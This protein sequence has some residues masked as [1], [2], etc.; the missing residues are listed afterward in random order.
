MASIFV[1]PV[2]VMTP[3]DN[4]S[5]EGIEVWLANLDIWLKEALSAH[6]A[7]LHS[8]Q[9]T[10][11]LQDS[12]RFP[13]FELLRNWQRKYRLD[14]NPSQLVRGV[15]EFF[16][17]EEFDLGSILEK[18]GYLIEPEADSIIIRPDQFTAR[19]PDFIQDDMHLLLATSCACKYTEHPFTRELH[20]AT[21]VLPDVAKEIEVSAVILDS[22][23]DFVRN[24]DNKIHQTFPLL[25]TPDDLLPLI[26]VIKLW[27]QGETGIIYA[28]EQ[29]YKKDW[30]NSVSK[31]LEFRIGL[32]FIESANNFGLNTN[33]NVLRK[34]VR[35]AGAIIADQ[36]K[37]IQAYQLHELRESKAAESR[38]RVRS[39]DNAKAW[40]L[41]IEKHG[42]GWRLH[43]WQIPGPGESIIEFSNVEKESGDKIYE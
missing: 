22:I 8:V 14:F 33:D 30:R 3:P 15:N 11:L 1:D 41:M 17:N 25:F 18:L 31:P 23:P 9:A 12:G 39:S 13:S 37:H 16:R 38:Q 28:I 24:A 7:W 34:I 20:I 2:I 32:H 29:Q 19:W 26:D 27:S 40:R 5:R 21:L 4:E 10:N 35:A 43:Y 36:A 6:Y 42:A